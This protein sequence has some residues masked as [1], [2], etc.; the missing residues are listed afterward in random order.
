MSSSRIF[1]LVYADYVAHY[2][3]RAESSA[4]LLLLV[5]PRMLVNPSMHAAILIRICIAG[6]RPLFF[7]WRNLLVAKHSMDIGPN[8]KVG[9]GLN[10]P[11]PFGLVMGTG[12]TLGRNVLLYHNV[13]L[14]TAR[15][16][17]QREHLPVP[18]VEDDVVIHP[19]SVIAGGV[20][21]G[22]RSVIGANSFVKH[23]LPP[24]TVFRRSSPEGTW[25][26]LS[27]E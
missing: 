6:P 12:V 23:D 4:R 2:N 19:N 13:T 1:S 5:L 21:I 9:P 10:L 26:R 24:N 20:T 16:P 8:C 15:A 17:G 25:G 11:H 14:G 3:N 22:A 7:I 18:I 27:A